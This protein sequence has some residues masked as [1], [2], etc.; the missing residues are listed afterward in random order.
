M[1]PVPITAYDIK[2]GDVVTGGTYFGHVP[3]NDLIDHKIMVPPNV[4]GRVK[5]IVAE[6][7]GFLCAQSI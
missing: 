7:S 3:E 6:V 1:T 5:S 2:V 4:M